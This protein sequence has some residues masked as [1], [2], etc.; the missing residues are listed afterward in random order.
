MAFGYTNKNYSFHSRHFSVNYKLRQKI[1]I[2][3]YTLQDGFVAGSLTH[4]NGAIRFI[5]SI[6]ST[7]GGSHLMKV[8]SYQLR[9]R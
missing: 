7:F 9:K 2:I 3:I 8:D 6:S 5:T 1:D 4:S